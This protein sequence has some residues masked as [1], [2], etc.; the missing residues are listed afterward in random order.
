MYSIHEYWDMYL[1]FG[2]CNGNAL[3]TVRDYACHYPSCHHL[4]PMSSTSWMTHWEILKVFCWQ[5]ISTACICH[6]RDRLR[7]ILSTHALAR[8]FN[9][10][11]NTVQGLHPADFQRCIDFCEW[12]LRQQEADNAFVACLV[13]GYRTGSSTIT[14][15]MCG[16]SPILM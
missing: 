3:W 8:Q 10:I 4:M 5:K 12:L 7:Q 1:I 9:V 16:H 13:D 2:K 14:T 6:H 15:A 11:K